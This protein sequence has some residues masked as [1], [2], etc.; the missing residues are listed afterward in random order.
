MVLTQYSKIECV[1]GALSYSHII[2]MFQCD[3]VIFPEMTLRETWDAKIFKDQVL[4]INI[5]CN[6]GFQTATN[7]FLFI[8][9]VLF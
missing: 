8:G 4:L 5:L 1:A 9:G 3:S 7:C 2:L 6:T